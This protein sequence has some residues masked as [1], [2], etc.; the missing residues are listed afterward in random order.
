[1]RSTCSIMTSLLYG[2]RTP[3]YYG[4]D[5]ELFFEGIKLVNETLDT[6]AFPPVEIMPF[7]D[8]I[9]KWIAP[10]CSLIFLSDAP[11]RGLTLCSGLR[12]SRRRRLFAMSSTSGYLKKLKKSLRKVII[13]TRTLKIFSRIRNFSTSREMR[14]CKFAYSTYFM[15]PL[16]SCNT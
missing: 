12:I 10:V 2:K 1:M 15:Y 3:K 8:Y 9:P 6:A 7:I 14:W 5:A 11:Y 13:R 4:T 16:M